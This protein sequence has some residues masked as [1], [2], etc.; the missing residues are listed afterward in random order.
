MGSTVPA[1]VGSDVISDC[2]G[3]YTEEGGEGSRYH[4]EGSL[5]TVVSVQL[6]SLQTRH[7]A[8]PRPDCIYSSLQPYRGE[9]V[10]PILQMSK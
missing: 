3:I 4:R 1:P 2:I 9:T 5:E 10:I 8:L 7:E 6:N